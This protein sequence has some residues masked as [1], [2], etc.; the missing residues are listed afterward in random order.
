MLE[1]AYPKPDFDSL[2]RI[3]EG[4]KMPIREDE[5]EDLTAPIKELMDNRVADQEATPPSP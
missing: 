1:L 5:M 4:G 3:P 2:K